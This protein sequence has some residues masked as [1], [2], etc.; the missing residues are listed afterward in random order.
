M[1]RSRTLPVFLL[2]LTPL[3]GCD[4]LFGKNQEDAALSCDESSTTLGFDELSALG[5][6]GA[7][8]AALAEGAH[9]DTFTYAEGG[10]TTGLTLTITADTTGARFIDSEPAEDTGGGMELDMSWCEDRLEV[11]LS[12]GFQTEDGAFAETWSGV[13][14]SQDG[15]DADFRADVDPAA[16]SGSFDADALL[17]DED[18]DSVEMW[19][20][21]SARDG[22][23]W[24][25]LSGQA[26]KVEDCEE[27]EECS[28]YAKILEVGSWGQM[29]G[30]DTGGDTADDGGEDD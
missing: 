24:G 12:I 26:T 15:V 20:S 21:G 19:L 6:S 3:T 30:S 4:G 13:L 29:P 2:A 25:E 7:Q 11:D 5:F 18:W 22:L 23:T 17:G 10:A 9:A 14:S 27:G 28:A 8:L 16:L 1:I